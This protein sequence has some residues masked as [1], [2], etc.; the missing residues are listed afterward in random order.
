M[1]SVAFAL[2]FC[3]VTG[4]LAQTPVCPTYVVQAGDSLYSI[5]QKFDILSPDDLTNALLACGQQTDLL[6]IGQEICLPGA[7]KPG[8]ANVRSY[9]NDDNCKVYIVQ[10]GDTIESVAN[11]LDIFRDTLDNLNK[12][13][14][15][16]GILQPNKYLKLPPWSNQCGDPNKSGESCRLYIVNSG[17]F[18]AGIAAAYGVTVDD[19]LSVN[20][21][22]DANSVLQNSQPIKIPPFPASCGAGV[23]SKPPTDTVLKCRGY[24]VQQGDNIQQIAQAF[25]TTVNDITAVNPELSGGALVQPGTIVKIPPYD[26][27]CDKPILVQIDN[28]GANPPPSGDSP[29]PAVVIALAPE[30][31]PTPAPSSSPGVHIVASAAMSILV[32]LFF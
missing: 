22:L 29:A 12:D 21:G 17:D 26:N 23:P 28:A 8:C 2:A 5:Q 19:L 13:V 4:V 30:I 11:S 16:G 25:K 6:Q 32:F 15:A 1:R 3:A 20:P 7:D 9:N 18:I 31:A 24:R 27:T 14:Q 10:Q